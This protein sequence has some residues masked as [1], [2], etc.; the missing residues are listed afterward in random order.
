M[1]P[2]YIIAILRKRREK[3]SLTE[4][5]KEQ[6]REWFDS[7]EG[8]TVFADAEWEKDLALYLQFD[9]DDQRMEDS[10]QR[11]YT[12][13][14]L[15]A[16][17]KAVPVRRIHRWVWA[18]ASIVLLFGAGTYLWNA[19]KHKTD[20]IEN[21][22]DITPGKKGAVLT[23]ADGSQIVLDSLHNG[24]IAAQNGAQV[25]LNEGGL[26]YDPTGSS[27]GA[28]AFNTVTTPNGREFVL[29]LPDG[30]KAWL[31]AAS[32][33]TYP[34]IFSGNERLVKIT[35]EAYFEVTANAKLPFIVNIN[36]QTKVQV[37]GTRFNV[38]A[39]NNEPG[40]NTTLLEG[41]VKVYFGHEHVLLKPGQQ[42]AIS[43]ASGNPRPVSI[44]TPDLEKVMA[45]KNGLFNFEKASLEEV[46]RQLERWYDVEV[47]YE[48]EIP[49][50]KLA[51]E[52]T[53]DVTLN[54][55]LLGLTELGIHTRLEGRKLIVLP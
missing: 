49:K 11:L 33:I 19:N 18:A 41:S 8:E 6:F 13:I 24:V 39:Y 3:Q 31:N 40:I 10:L 34:T 20:V 45:W 7:E 50:V 35:G 47:V 14:A 43:L 54:G 21:V 55:L 16:P 46:M 9:A 17:Q 12:A 1:V 25:L 51:G 29:A 26:V 53:K 38:N 22:A 52:M 23:L 32:S 42:A 15:T 4:V 37:L 36:D 44:Q 28:M 5:E 48:K 2:E 30:T 27:S